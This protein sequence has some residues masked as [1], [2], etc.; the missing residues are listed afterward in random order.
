M[1]LNLGV[2][3]RDW[4]RINTY[5]CRRL[6]AAFQVLPHIKLLRKASNLTNQNARA[7]V[8]WG[9]DAKDAKVSRIPTEEPSATL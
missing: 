4:Q 5:L 6:L 7:E 3:Y 1:S 8:V 2:W 9:K